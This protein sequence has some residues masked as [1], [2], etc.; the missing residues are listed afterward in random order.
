MLMLSLRLEMFPKHVAHSSSMDK[1][2]GI[3]SQWNGLCFVF[4][5]RKFVSS[6]KSL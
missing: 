5:R 1:P 2:E 6:T 3:C 4:I